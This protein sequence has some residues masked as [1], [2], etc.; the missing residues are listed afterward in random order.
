MFTVGQFYEI[1][2]VEYDDDGRICIDW[3][4]GCEAIEVQ[5]PVVKFRQNGD[6]IIVNTASPYFAGTN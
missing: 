5:M 3:R 1:G 4:A 6:E 2:F